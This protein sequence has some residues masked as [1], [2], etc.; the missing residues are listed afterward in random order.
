MSKSA[1]RGLLAVAVV[2]LL[3]SAYAYGRWTAKQEAA[4]YV[5]DVSTHLVLSCT[6]E[7]VVALTDLREGKTE[8]AVRGLELLVAAKLEGIDVAR[9]PS[10]IIA[11]KSFEGLRAPLV[12]Y[13][14]KFPTTT[15]DPKKNPRLDNVM[16]AL[17]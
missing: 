4:A 8:D 3:A 14:T 11:K 7:H 1:I 13:Q 2:I 9:I 16:R 12:A 15:L 5:Y 10:T 6:N 17:K